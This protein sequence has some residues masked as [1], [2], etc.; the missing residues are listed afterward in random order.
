MPVTN[1]FRIRSSWYISIVL[2]LLPAYYMLEFLSQLIF[3]INLI[4]TILL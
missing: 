3:V 4:L 2:K 1:L